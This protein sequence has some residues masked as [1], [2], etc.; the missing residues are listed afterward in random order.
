MASDSRSGSY[1]SIPQKN[2]TAQLA[3]IDTIANYAA[4]SKYFVVT[5]PSTYHVNTGRVC[6]AKSYLG[7]GWVS[8]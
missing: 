8:L 7:R 5:A 1:S 6:D 3:A 4:L 2:Q